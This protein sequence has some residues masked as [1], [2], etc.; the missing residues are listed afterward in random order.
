[1]SSCVF[2]AQAKRGERWLP[3]AMGN[4]Q[5]Q[6][7]HLIIFVK[8]ERVLRFVFVYFV[9]LKALQVWK[10]CRT[11]CY[12]G[13]NNA[14]SNL[15]PWPGSSRSKPTKK[16]CTVKRKEK[17]RQRE[18][19]TDKQMW[20]TRSVQLSPMIPSRSEKLPHP[21]CGQRSTPHSET[22]DRYNVCNPSPQTR[23]FPFK[24]NHRN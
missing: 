11:H 10:A 18:K 2:P 21:C 23:Q 20:R 9:L 16:T 19:A 17:G 8:T 24:Q 14:L 7:R 15:Q 6:G 1:M 22:S 5:C 12:C 4:G 3:M 13:I